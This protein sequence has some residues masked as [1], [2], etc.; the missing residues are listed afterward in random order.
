VHKYN[1]TQPGDPKADKPSV[2]VEPP[3]ARQCEA[4]QS[5][6]DAEADTDQCTWIDSV[7]VFINSA[8]AI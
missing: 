8:A 2:I 1:V 7:D 6:N 5:D 3:H 4:E